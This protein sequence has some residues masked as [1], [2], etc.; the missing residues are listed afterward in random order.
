MTD[1]TTEPESKIPITDAEVDSLCGLVGACQMEVPR[2]PVVR[3]IAEGAE[4]FLRRRLRQ[5]AHPE[6]VRIETTDRGEPDRELVIPLYGTEEEQHQLI[7]QV[8][9][10]FSDTDPEWERV[11]IA[12][13]IAEEALNLTIANGLPVGEAERLIRLAIDYATE[14]APKVVAVEGVPGRNTQDPET[15]E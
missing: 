10:M 3:A 9:A 13:K 6:A 1:Q 14:Q 5:L 15:D 8:A 7:Q 11:E 4:V 12:A 2:P